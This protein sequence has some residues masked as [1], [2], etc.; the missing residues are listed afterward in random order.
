MDVGY[1]ALRFL[2]AINLVELEIKLRSV[3]VDRELARS[4]SNPG[5]IDF[6]GREISDLQALKADL[7]INEMS[8]IDR[9][10]EKYHDQAPSFPHEREHFEDRW[11]ITNVNS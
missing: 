2:R 11:K 1:R 6:L 5:I 7:N 4:D 10:I 3:W 8:A 9:V